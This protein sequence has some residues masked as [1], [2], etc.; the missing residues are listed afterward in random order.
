MVPSGSFFCISPGSPRSALEASSL[1]SV[2]NAS[3]KRF[4]RVCLF[5]GEIFSLSSV[6]QY[7]A[8]GSVVWCCDEVFCGLGVRIDGV[9]ISVNVER[10]LM[11]L[12]GVRSAM[13]VSM[14]SLAV[15]TVAPRPCGPVT[16]LAEGF[17]LF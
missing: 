16:I 11:L 7:E 9:V 12:L 10:P 2:K 4:L 1:Q 3:R 8:E 13:K 6:W 14:P 5:S 17:R 15:C